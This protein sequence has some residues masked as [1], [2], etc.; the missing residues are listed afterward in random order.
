MHSGTGQVVELILEDGQRAARISCPANL[1]PS[2]GQYLLASDASDSPL[3]VPVFY[4][5]SAPQGVAVAPWRHFIAAP[6]VPDSWNP[7]H[8]IYLRGPLGHGFAIPVSARKVGLIAFDDSP[9]RLRGLIR[10]SLSQGAAVVLVSDFASGSLPNDV[11]VQPLST[12]PEIIEWAD[13][14]AFDAARENLP[15]LREKLRTLD[16]FSAGAK[17]EAQ[18]L[19]RTPVPCG[20]VAECGVCAVTLKSNWRMACKD[21]PVFGWNELG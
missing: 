7:G 18:I 14:V 13:Y 9:S 6:P 4:T 16:Q 19:I 2:P 11:E 8:E 1:I 10:P 5:D 21:G 12:L 3:P 15:E 20:G 17:R